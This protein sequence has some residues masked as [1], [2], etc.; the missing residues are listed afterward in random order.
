MRN[1]CQ[2]NNVGM[3]L[4]IL[5]CTHVCTYVSMYV[6]TCVR[7]YALYELYTIYAIYVMYIILLH[8]MPKLYSHTP[9]GFA[10]LGVTSWQGG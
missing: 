5:V 8:Y 6:C 7:E 1:V 9:G 10:S 3:E 4:H 2:V